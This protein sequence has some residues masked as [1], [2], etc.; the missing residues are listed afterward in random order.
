MKADIASRRAGARARAILAERIWYIVMSVIAVFV[1]VI[2]GVAA[3]ASQ[4]ITCQA[5]HAS[6]VHAAQADPHANVPCDQ[7]HSGPG[8]AGL[9]KTRLSVN[10]MVVY[11]LVPSFQRLAPKVRSQECLVCHADQ[12]NKT[13]T[14]RGMRMNHV[15]PLQAGWA[16]QTCHGGVG[17]SGTAGSGATYTMDM[18]MSCHSATP[19]NPKTCEICHSS[20]LSGGSLG[21]SSVSPWSVTHGPNWRKTH[22]MGDLTTCKGCHASDFCNKCHVANVPH[23]ATYLITHGP[24]VLARPNGSTACLVCHQQSACDNCHG[25]IPMPHPHGFL[26]GHSALVKSVGKTS[27][28][29]CHQQQSCDG[30]HTRHTHPG[31]PSDTLKALQQHPVSVP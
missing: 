31:I 25:G 24:E 19:S 4:P 29:K 13:S 11:Q 2:A 1:I 28:L 26:K 5:C 7:C 23:P 27:C 6:L 17:H 8:V 16:C 10:N 9:V 15:A 22:G 21:V 3:A 20:Q 14:T 12:M 18:C 30:C